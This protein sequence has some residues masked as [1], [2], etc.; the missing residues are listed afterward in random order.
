MLKLQSIQI[1]AMTSTELAAETEIIPAGMLCF[2]INTGIFK[3]GTGEKTYSNLPRAGIDDLAE[4]VTLDGLPTYSF[5]RNITGTALSTL[6]DV[7]DDIGSRID[8]LEGP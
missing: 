2:E 7:L 6:A 3:I 4:Y 1:A 5:G 8:V